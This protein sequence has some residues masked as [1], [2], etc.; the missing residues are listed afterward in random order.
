MK[1]S[2]RYFPI[3]PRHVEGAFPA[4]TQSST[5]RS[6]LFPGEPLEQAP[7]SKV[8]TIMRPSRPKTG[9]RVLNFMAPIIS[10]KGVLNKSVNHRFL[11]HW[12]AAIDAGRSPLDLHPEC[13]EVLRERRLDP[14][15]MPIDPRGAGLRAI[16]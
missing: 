2:D 1:R 13:R 16:L 9:A 15:A 10:E 3:Q 5:L 4:D 7:T 6:F 8:Q 14:E 12:G 11:M